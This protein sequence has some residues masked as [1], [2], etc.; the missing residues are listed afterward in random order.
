MQ[1][2]YLN[3][4]NQTARDNT[5]NSFQS[6]YHRLDVING[7]LIHL[8]ENTTAVHI[9]INHTSI[10]SPKVDKVTSMQPVN[11]ITDY[12]SVV[13]LNDEI[14]TKFDDTKQV[15][16]KEQAEQE[17]AQEQSLE[18]HHARL[19]N[20]PDLE[21]L[22]LLTTYLR[23]TGKDD[24]NYTIMGAPVDLPLPNEVQRHIRQVF[25]WDESILY[26]INTTLMSVLNIAFDMTPLN[27]DLVDNLYAMHGHQTVKVLMYNR[28]QGSKVSIM[29]FGSLLGYRL[30]P[31]GV[32]VLRLIKDLCN[33]SLL[34][35]NQPFC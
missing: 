4:L 17:Q 20:I 9:F 21:F 24:Q 6:P 30:T 11:T 15:M 23:T 27:L 13:R 3:F 35:S 12:V 7:P 34:S 29:N 1:T 18:R 5:V 2:A 28:A 8:A 32:D 19:L 10:L 26:R 14:R 22:G 33:F 25:L 31:T 16:E